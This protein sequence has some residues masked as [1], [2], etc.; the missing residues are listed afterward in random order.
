M[1]LNPVTVTVAPTGRSSFRHP[2]RYIPFELLNQTDQGS[3]WPF[4]FVT[5][6]VSWACGFLHSIFAIVPMTVVV[7]A[8]SK[9]AAI[10]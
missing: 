5:V 9:P 1:A 2:R 6:I 4:S 7:P 10:E 8:M 3:I